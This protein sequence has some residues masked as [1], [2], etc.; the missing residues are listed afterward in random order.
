MNIKVKFTL[1]NTKNSF[2]RIKIHSKELTLTYNPESGCPDWAL[3][4]ISS[5]CVN[6][7]N[8]HRILFKSKIQNDSES[9]KIIKITSICLQLEERF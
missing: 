5:D 1:K 6:N 2:F 3:V 7:R 9:F 8:K 4:T